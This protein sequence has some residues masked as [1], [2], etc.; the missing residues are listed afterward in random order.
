LKTQFKFNSKNQ[1]NHQLLDYYQK[2]LDL[3]F[4][5]N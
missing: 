4:L 2:Q 1:V 3:L 5:K